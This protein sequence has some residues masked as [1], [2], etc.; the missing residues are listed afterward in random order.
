VADVSGNGNT[1]TIANAT[2]T[3]AGKYGNAL[4]FNGTSS[5]VTI[6]DA[7]SL[8]LTTGMTLEAWVN[9]SAVS[10]AWRDVIYKGDDN[11]YLSATSTKNS[12]PAGGGKLGS[13]TVTETYGTA[14]LPVN[15]WTYL[16]VTYDGLALRLYVN[17]TQV[18]SVAH[19]GNIV[20]STNPLQIGG[21][22]IYGQ[23]FKGMIDE[24]RVYNVA[25]TT[26]QIQADMTKPLV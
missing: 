3:T 11:Y 23:Y 16:A 25:L 19:T 4:S 2:W 17:G 8:H 1:G 12:V 6:P 9:P 5:R 22:S 20:T 7:L 14:A 26:A 21:D 15:T 18:S 24:V 10:S 13:S